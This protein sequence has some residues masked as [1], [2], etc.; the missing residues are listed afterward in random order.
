M[1]HIIFEYS[2]NLAETT[3]V[4]RLF[5]SFHDALAGLGVEIDDCKSRAYRCDVYCVGRGPQT[6]GFVHVTLA[7]LDHRPSEV[8][9]EQ[10]NGCS[11][12]SSAASERMSTVT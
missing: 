5:L 1:P 7:V 4:Q 6:R 12:S 11:R 8:Q 9:R 10:A 3:D 2:A